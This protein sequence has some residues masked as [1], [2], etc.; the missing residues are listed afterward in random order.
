MLTPNKRTRRT[1]VHA[2]SWG[3]ACLRVESEENSFQPV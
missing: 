1:T 3:K 2:E